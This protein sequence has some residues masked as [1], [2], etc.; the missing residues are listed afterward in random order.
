[1]TPKEAAAQ[2]WPTA[3]KFLLEIFP[4]IHAQVLFQVLMLQ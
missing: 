4:T 1:M 2:S 3:D